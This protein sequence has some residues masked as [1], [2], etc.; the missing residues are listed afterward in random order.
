M[1]ET[2]T[3]LTGIPHMGRAVF[4]GAIIGALTV[5]LP[6]T[7]A[8][9]SFGAGPISA[10][11]GAHVGFFGGMGYGGMVGAVVRS[12]RWERATNTA[13]RLRGSKIRGIAPKPRRPYTRTTRSHSPGIH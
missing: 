8:L 10:L 3:S 13:T 9:I 1:N 4:V 7:I 2:T 12:G 5:A 11:F 6:V